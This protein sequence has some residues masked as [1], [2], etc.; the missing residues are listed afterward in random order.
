MNLKWARG[1]ENYRWKPDWSSRTDL[2]EYQYI[3]ERL[4]IIIVIY[5]EK[6]SWDESKLEYKLFDKG[7]SVLKSV[8]N[9]REMEDS[10]E[11]V[12]KEMMTKQ[13]NKKVLFD[14]VFK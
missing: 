13:Q 12:F 3:H 1:F 9:E 6:I 11:E 10:L 5:E 7:V 4:K 14:G 2:E 8:S